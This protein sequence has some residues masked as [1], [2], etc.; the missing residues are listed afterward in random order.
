MLGMM[1][2]VAGKEGDSRKWFEDSAGEKGFDSLAGKK[3]GLRKGLGNSPC[4]NI[5]KNCR[6]FL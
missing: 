3:R 5:L 6:V 4:A 2:A 1:K